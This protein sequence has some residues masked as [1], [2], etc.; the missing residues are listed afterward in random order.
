MAFYDDKILECRFQNDNYEF[1][2]K[3]DSAR[4]FWSF[5][6]N[7]RNHLA[8]FGLTA[9]IEIPLNNRLETFVNGYKSTSD[10]NSKLII[11]Q[12]KISI[13]LE[14]GSIVY[15]ELRNKTRNKSYQVLIDLDTTDNLSCTEMQ[16]IFEEFLSKKE[17]KEKFEKFT[18]SAYVGLNR[19][20]EIDT[21]ELLD[22]SEKNE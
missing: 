9:S 13:R 5:I 21:F 22:I 19:K 12:N 6:E 14:D 18:N 17:I 3:E 8:F 11:A 4:N 2:Y 15:P 20:L 7:S 1:K 16:D 10:L